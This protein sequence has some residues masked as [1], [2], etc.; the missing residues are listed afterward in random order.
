MARL[1]DVE[2]LVLLACCDIRIGERGPY[3][4]GM[5][6]VALNVP[7][8]AWPLEPLKARLDPRHLIPT[9]LHSRVY[10][11][12]GSLAAGLVDQL[13]PAGE[14]MKTALE[15]AHELAKLP[16]EAYGRSKRELRREALEI[17]AADLGLD[18]V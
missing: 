12:E 15:A 3:K 10:D 17:M 2:R 13:V 4:F 9:L 6:E 1:D 16:G 5:T 18:Q 11:P 8:S 7:F 14:G